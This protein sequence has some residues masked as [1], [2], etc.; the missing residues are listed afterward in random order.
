LAFRWAHEA[1]PEAQLFYNDYE[2]EGLNPKSDAIY[3]LVRGLRKRGVPIH[4]VGLQ[5]HVTTESPPRAEEVTVN[6]N[7]LAS[8]GLKVQITEMDVR[9]G[10]TVTERELARQARIYGDMLGACL[11]A[12][13][14]T[15]FVL[16]GFTDRYSWIPHSFPRHNS[17]LIFD[18]SYHPKPA[19]HELIDVLTGR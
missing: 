18:A 6:M 14:C 3:K 15:A 4:G 10:R 19:Y 12:P 11:S 1:D 5:M 16:W 17:A 2:G 13:N 9:T 7:R 8:L